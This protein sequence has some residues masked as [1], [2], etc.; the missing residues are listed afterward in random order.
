MFAAAALALTVVASPLEVMLDRTA[1][2]RIKEEGETLAQVGFS[3]FRSGWSYVSTQAGSSAPANPMIARAPWS[4][5]EAQVTGQVTQLADGLRYELSAAPNASVGTESTSLSV[6]LPSGFWAGGTATV[7]GVSVPFPAAY[8]DLILWSGSAQNVTFSK[9]DLQITFESSASRSSLLQDSRQWGPNFEWRYGTQGGTWASGQTRSWTVTLKTNRAA[10]FSIEEPLVISEGPDWVPITPALDVVPGSALDWTPASRKPAGSEGWVQAQNG[11]FTLGGKPRRFYG[12]NL[13]FTACY[14][15]KAEATRLADRLAALGYNAVRLHHFDVDLTGGWTRSGSSS[16]Q[17]DPVMLD[18]L[19]HLVAALKKRGLYISLDLFTIRQIRENEVV[20]GIVGMD[21]YKALMLVSPSAR[22]NLLTFSSNLLNTL[23]PYTGL[24]WKDDPAIAWIVPVN[25]NNMGS[26]TLE[27]S[28]ASRTLFNQAWQQAGNSGSWSYETDAGARF[29]A[30]L[31]SQF[32]EWMKTQLRAIGVRALLSDLNGWR[33]QRVF[34]DNRS[35][36]DYVD[37]HTYW[38]HPSF[39]A[40]AWGPPSAGGSGSGMAVKSLGGGIPSLALTRIQGKPFVVS[41]F[42]FTSPN[43]YRAEG[44]LFFG[45]VAARQDWSGAFRFAWSHSSDAIRSP[46]PMDYFNL[47]SDPASLA[48]ERAIVAL[49]LRRDMEPAPE[50][51]VL[52]VDVAAAGAAQGYHAP[53]SV[54]ILT[55]RLSSSPT[56]GGNGV[57]DPPTGPQPTALDASRGILTVNTARTQGFFAPPGE[58][59]EVGQ[60]RATLTGHRAALWATSLDDRPL[61]SSRRILLN[62]VTDSQNSGARFRGPDRDVLE[63]WGTLPYLARA[64]GATISLAHSEAH[65][66]KVYRLDLAG[67]RVALVPSAASGGRLAFSVSVAGTGGATW[68][69][70]I[71]TDGPG[72]AR[73][74]PG[75]GGAAKSGSTAN[76]SLGV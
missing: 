20:P 25:E 30:Q 70:E 14:L 55:R 54:Q 10:T 41:E 49:F 18:R 4:G 47:Q 58:Q 22:Q 13:A 65:L 34:A 43:R 44:G 2:L 35:R 68:H 40:Q 11:Q 38:D 15:D 48:T 72:R 27:L 71:T 17:L 66:L 75:S 56:Q 59:L 60:I 45:S 6:N 28:P 67:R 76:M 24:R 33:D 9:G 73:G 57:M 3:F 26:S 52:R 5:G 31:H 53:F 39:L 37:N 12:V 61:S 46:Q 16:T 7:D 1:G 42:N 23:N 21:E 74:G 51:G 63:A 50:E 32:Y 64:G 29:G 36:L 8:Q 19:N 69:Y 62:H